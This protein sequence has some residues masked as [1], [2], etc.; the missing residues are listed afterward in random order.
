MGR[1]TIIHSMLSEVTFSGFP[2]SRIGS[3]LWPLVGRHY[4]VALFVPS[5]KH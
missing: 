3:L 4:I 5:Q 1:H 2:G